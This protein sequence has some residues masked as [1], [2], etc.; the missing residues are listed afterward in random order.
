MTDLEPDASV[1]ALDGET[2]GERLSIRAQPSA[3]LLFMERIDAVA[4]WLRHARLACVD[5]PPEA[6]KAAEWLLDNDYFVDR[7]LKQISKDMPAGFFQ[8]LPSLSGVDGNP[9]RAVSYTHL[10]LPTTSRV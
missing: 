5:P 6:G 2:L 3:P 10:T 7:A 4:D 9:P 1:L 8:R